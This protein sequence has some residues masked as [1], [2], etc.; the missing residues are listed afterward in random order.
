MLPHH[1]LRQ[2]GPLP[3]T[4][5]P[6]IA[7][8]LP[9]PPRVL[10]APRRSS[11]RTLPTPRAAS[12]ERARSS[13]G[14]EGDGEG[15]GERPKGSGEAAGKARVSEGPDRGGQGAPGSGGGD[16]GSRGRRRRGPGRPRGPG[17]RA[18]AA[19][20][21]PHRQ[22]RLP[23]RARRR[24]RRKLRRRL[25]AAEVKLPQ[26]S[27]VNSHRGG[28]G[29]ARGRPL[30]RLSAAAPP[31]P[32]PR[33]LRSAR[34]PNSPGAAAA[35]A[36]GA[37]PGGRWRRPRCS[38]GLRRPP[39]PPAAPVRPTPRGRPGGLRQTPG[40]LARAPPGRRGPR[41]VQA[42]RASRGTATAAPP[43]HSRYRRWGWARCPGGGRG[44]RRGRPARLSP[45]VGGPGAQRGRGVRVPAKLAPTRAGAGLARGHLRGARPASEKGP[46][47][48]VARFRPRRPP[49]SPRG[50]GGCWER[51]PETFSDLRV[52]FTQ[53]LGAGCRPSS[54]GAGIPVGDRDGVLLFIFLCDFQKLPPS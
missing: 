34:S 25:A 20:S 16:R 35:G 44:A 1:I 52:E 4:I 19:A 23:W 24:R 39:P 22:S 38:P 54:L 10:P 29:G 53:R 48:Q 50:S 9:G 33:D 2:P 47:F 8:G 26:C 14:S 31:P 36:C 27:R 41:G 45:G 15:S 3:G 42:P 5:R 12:G 32:P 7:A 43:P 6:R 28:G 17:E 51:G 46:G 40:E 21:G 30:R 18:G 49:P 37:K 11:Q 13:R